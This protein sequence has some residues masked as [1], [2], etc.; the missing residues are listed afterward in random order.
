MILPNAPGGSLDVV[1]RHVGAKLTA[2]FG[3]PIIYDNRTGAGGNIAAEL[4]ARSKPDGYTLYVGFPGT[5]AA[6]IH[7]FDHLNYDP[8]KDFEPI[9]LMMTA[10]FFLFINAKLPYST[11]PGL[12]AAAK[13]NPGKL[14]FGSTGNGSASHM[15][16][17][18]FRM[19]AGVDITHVPYK[20]SVVAADIDVA[21]GRLEGKFG[22]AS[23]ASQF[24][25]SG[26]TR[27]LAVTSLQRDKSYP[28][29][30]P[31]ADMVPGY[32]YT[33]WVGLLAPKGLPQ[34]ILRKLNAEIR[35]IQADPEMQARFQAIG[36]NAVS[37]TPQEFGAWIVSETKKY[38]EIVK[39]SGGSIKIE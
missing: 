31:L 25:K 28:E 37:S 38:G 17:I 7:L 9:S 21:A 11:V 27:S 2:A 30:P 22:T 20:G 5:H 36:L 4:A 18:L 19:L 14:N 32:E 39:A 13:A 26:M 3:Q 16:L 6:N 24:T 15:A 35:K 8:V 10:P 29:I 23:G 34:D 33:T 1:A 12:I